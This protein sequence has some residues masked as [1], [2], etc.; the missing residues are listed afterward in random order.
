MKVA[1]RNCG[2]SVEVQEFC[3]ECGAA[4]PQLYRE[5]Q[6]LREAR[7]SRRVNRTSLGVFLVGSGAI[8]A[9]IVLAFSL[10]ALG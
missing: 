6:P 7:S 5:G 9:L 4:L 2:A 10:G 8:V 1:C 3:P